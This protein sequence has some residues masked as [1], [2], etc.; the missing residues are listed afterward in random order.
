MSTPEILLTEEQ[1]L[2]FTQISQNISK[3]EIVKY[4]TFSEFDIEIINRHR[5]D[6]NKL[7]FALQLGFIRNLGCSI[8]NID[9]VPISVLNYISDQLNV[10]ILELDQY[11]KRE[12]T[13]REHLQEIRDVYRYRNFTDKEFLSLQ[14]EIFAHALENDNA[15]SLMKIAISKLR[16]KNIILPGITVLEKAVNQARIKAEEHI[17]EIINN[18]LSKQQKLLMNTLINGEDEEAVTKLGWLRSDIGFPSPRTFIE[19]IDK[20]NKIRK[21]RLDLNIK[22]LHRNRIHQLYRLGSKYE[23]HS[24]RRFDQSKRYAILAIYL[25]ELSQTL[26]DKAIEIHDRQINQL[27]S[28]GRKK[29]E[30]IQ[31]ENCCR[32]PRY[33][34]I[35]R[36]KSKYS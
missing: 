22:G 3:W 28:K 16:K 8:S 27:L 17:F 35:Y 19:I 25:H 30:E 14:E 5:R 10:S 1:R 29:H 21:L 24:F 32:K 9:A 33:K 11:A 4:Y 18:S 12:N 34:R 15:I 13:R 26:I 6:Y 7:G 23:P 31:R 2:E 20:L 36:R